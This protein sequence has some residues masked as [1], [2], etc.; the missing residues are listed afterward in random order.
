[1]Y[2]GPYQFKMAPVEHFF[3][4]LKNRDLNPLNTRAYSK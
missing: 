1:M 3:A 4:Y 2:L